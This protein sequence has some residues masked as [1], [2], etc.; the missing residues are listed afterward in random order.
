MYLYKSNL[1]R[2]LIVGDVNTKLNSLNAAIFSVTKGIVVLWSDRNNGGF[3][4]ET[5]CRDPNGTRLHLNSQF[6]T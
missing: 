3:D 2:K 4:P 5:K 6:W 1:I